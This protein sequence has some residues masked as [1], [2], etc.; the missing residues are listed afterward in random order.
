MP[1]LVTTIWVILPQAFRIVIPPITNEFVALLK[2]TSLLALIGTTYATRELTDFARSFA[3]SNS[4]Q[5][6]YL[7]SAFL[8]LLVTIPL[9]YLAGRLEKKLAVKK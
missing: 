3:T 6:P 7:I 2:D 8:Y 9:T 5:T 4:N 1:N